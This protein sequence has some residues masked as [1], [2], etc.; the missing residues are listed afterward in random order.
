MASTDIVVDIGLTSEG[1]EALA[2]G[3]PI[4]SWHVNAFLFQDKKDREEF[5][6]KNTYILLKSVKVALPSKEDCGLIAQKALQDKLQ[7]IRAQAHQ[8]E[9]EINTR[10]SEL[11]ALTYE[12]SND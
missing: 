7:E 3:L 2:K 4:Y 6:G 12:A 1:A 10:I 9:S 5:F 8:D 11:L